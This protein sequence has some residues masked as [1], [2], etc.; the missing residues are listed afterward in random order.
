MIRKSK[1]S[2]GSWTTVRPDQTVISHGQAHI[3]GTTSVRS[4]IFPQRIS[5]FC[6]NPG[7]TVHNAFTTVAPLRVLGFPF[8]SLHRCIRPTPKH[9]LKK[10][11]IK[12][13]LVFPQKKNKNLC[14]YM[15]IWLTLINFNLIII[16]CNLVKY[17][18]QIKFNNKFQIQ[19]A[20]LTWSL[21][22]RNRNINFPF[23]A[24]KRF[25]T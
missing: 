14:I 16:H 19:K 1:I 9:E 24:D 4:S 17:L 7:G 12:Q 18:T 3:S 22:N 21:N 2:L 13:E 8:S 15:R 11:I 5:S 10:V 25:P 6:R 23:Y 20:N